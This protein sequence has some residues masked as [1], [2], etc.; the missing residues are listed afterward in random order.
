VTVP[1]SAHRDLKA[2]LGEDIPLDEDMH[3]QI[4]DFGTAKIT[5]IEEVRCTVINLITG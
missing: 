2:L 5:E 4:T 1:C 3:V